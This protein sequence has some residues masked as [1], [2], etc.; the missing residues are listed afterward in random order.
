MLERVPADD[1]V[2]R[3]FDMFRREIFTAEHCAVSAVR[4]SPVRQETWVD[5]EAMR[6][7]L[8]TQRQQEIA[9]AA[10]D[11]EHLFAA[12]VVEGGD[13]G[14]Q[15]VREAVERS[16][17]VLG[18]L[19]RRG[20]V[21][22]PFVER[23]VEDE[24]TRLAERQIDGVPRERNRRVSRIEQNAALNRNAVYAVDI[25]ERRGSATWARNHGFM[26]RRRIVHASTISRSGI[27]TTKRP[28]EA[29]KPRC[30]RMISS[31]KFQGRITT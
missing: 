6:S 3:H 5:P 1:E 8:C 10:A 2:G 19:R 24:S 23:L 28:P 30:W 11:F 29:R 26:S 12:Q 17:K 31:R 4:R 16:G 20:I 15:L 7:C 25:R 27:G 22:E 13:L 9:L 14:D 18:L 21:Q